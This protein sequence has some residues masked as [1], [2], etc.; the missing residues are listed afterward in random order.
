V[1]TSSNLAG[2]AKS[3]WWGVSRHCTSA[4]ILVT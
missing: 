2:C 3:G 4:H 1:L